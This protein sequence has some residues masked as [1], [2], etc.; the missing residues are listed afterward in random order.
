MDRLRYVLWKETD[1]PVVKIKQTVSEKTADSQGNEAL[2]AGIDAVDIIPLPWIPIGLKHQ[3][4][5]TI[6]KEAVHGDP[7]TFKI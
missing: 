1:D 6:G 7:L 5:A 2:G 3:G 4:A